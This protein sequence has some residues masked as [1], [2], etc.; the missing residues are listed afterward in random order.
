MKNLT[1]VVFSLLVAHLSQ[2]QQ[3]YLLLPADTPGTIIINES[4]TLKQI[5]SQKI[6]VNRINKFNGYRIE[7][8]QGSDRKVAQE[9]LEKF[10]EENPGIPA[11]MVFES[12]YVKIKVGIFRSKLEAQKLFFK[13]KNEHDGAKIVY[14]NGLAF[15]PLNSKPKQERIV[16]PIRIEDF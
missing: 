13:M 8:Y 7:I 1:L 4:Y 16:K 15:P 3:D 9:I 6:K 5:S 14:G 2:A 12:P 10:K 11:E